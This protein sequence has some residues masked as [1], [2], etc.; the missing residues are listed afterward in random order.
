MVQ[1][2]NLHF[3]IGD[4]QTPKVDSSKLLGLAEIIQYN[5]YIPEKR[6]LFSELD[7]NLKI[8]HLDNHRVEV[9]SKIQRLGGHTVVTLLKKYEG[10]PYRTICIDI[11]KKLKIKTKP[12]DKVEDLEAK[13]AKKVT[14]LFKDKINKMSNDEKKKY[15]EALNKNPDALKELKKLEKDPRFGEMLK[16]P[17]LKKS[18]KGE[19][20]TLGVIAM[21]GEAGFAPFLYFSTALGGLSGAL[22]ITLPFGV[23]IAGSQALAVVL[24]P[25]GWLGAGALI[26][27]K[28][29]SPNQRR[30]LPAVVYIG[31][32]RRE[33]L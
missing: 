8:K 22:G 14:L 13:I 7:E 15:V 4:K 25:V 32:L 20:G 5:P 10:V 28:I 18:F 17:K 2:D 27:N 29:A 3:L 11:C 23:Y 9:V 16:N 33:L 1:D 26:I 30:L 24:G 31:Q 21:A 12:T 6:V 19:L